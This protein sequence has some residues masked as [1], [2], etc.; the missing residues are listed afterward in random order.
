M[1]SLGNMK[2]IAVF[3]LSIV[4]SCI[5]QILPTNIIYHATNSIDKFSVITYYPQYYFTTTVSNKFSFP[6]YP[7]IYPITG[8]PAFIVKTNLN[9]QKISG[10]LKATYK[11][12]ASENVVFR[13]GG[14]GNWNT[15]PTPPH[16]RLFFSSK[17][18]YRNNDPC[19]ECSW[20]SQDGW[21]TLSNGAYTIQAL[22]DYTKW[23]DSYAGQSS[24]NFSRA[25]TN[26]IE[27]GLSFG[28]GS[29]Y[30]VGVAADKA[31]FEML[32]MQDIEPIQIKLES[33]FD[34]TNWLEYTNFTF[35]PTNDNTFFRL[36]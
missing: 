16:A 10:V 15:G 13:F 28:G 6:S 4:L 33:S 27:L 20:W 8:F 24:N 31:E 35:L 9:P 14:Q 26:V 29:F 21:Q 1:L 18:G 22:L 25:L 2:Y 36:K 17:I 3:L 12:A 19:P 7:L 30:D 23:T 5:G 32:S 34:L 11:V